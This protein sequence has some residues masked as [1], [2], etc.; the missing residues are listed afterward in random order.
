MA[1]EILWHYGAGKNK[2]S[3]IESWISE[4]NVKKTFMFSSRPLN[5]RVE[6]VNRPLP[7]FFV[8]AST[9][10]VLQIFVKRYRVCSCIVQF[11]R[12]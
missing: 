3:I 1:L 6:S 4:R 11:L 8:V 5:L 2:D 9:C 10:E 12:E 7:E